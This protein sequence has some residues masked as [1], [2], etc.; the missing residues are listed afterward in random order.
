[1]FEAFIIY[2]IAFIALL[3]VNFAV[4]FKCGFQNTLYHK[5]FD[6][7]DIFYNYHLSFYLWDKH[8]TWDETI[9][10]RIRRYLEDRENWRFILAYPIASLLNKIDKDHCV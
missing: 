6:Y 9:S 10:A 7:C 8:K 3:F 2:N 5:L 4:I 1:M